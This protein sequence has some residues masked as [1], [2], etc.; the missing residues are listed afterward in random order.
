MRKENINFKAMNLYQTYL[1]LRPNNTT[2]HN[3]T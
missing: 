3:T 2:Q 1:K